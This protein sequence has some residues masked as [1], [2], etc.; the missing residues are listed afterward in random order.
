MVSG[1]F[2]HNLEKIAEFP[3]NQGKFQPFGKL[4]VEISF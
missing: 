4:E 2:C 3:L 1:K